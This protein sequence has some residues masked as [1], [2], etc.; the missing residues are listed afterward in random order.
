MMQRI[1]RHD[2]HHD[3]WEIRESK[4]YWPPPDFYNIRGAAITSNPGF[5]ENPGATCWNLLSKHYLPPPKILQHPGRGRQL[6]NP[7][8]GR[9]LGSGFRE[10]PGAT[11]GNLLSKHYLPPPGFCTTSGVWPSPQTPDFRKIRE[12][13]AGTYFPS[14]IC[15]LPDFY[16]IRGAAGSSNPVVRALLA[17]S[18][19]LQ[20]PGLPDF[21]NIRGAAQPP[22]F[23]EIRGLGIG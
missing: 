22:D 8:A 19:F 18:G 14:T 5:R 6:E 7:G 13:P 11:C 15:R 17:A 10:N 4:H 23:P 12:Q 1:R 3:C 2:Y 20:H 16:N 9:V 21:Y